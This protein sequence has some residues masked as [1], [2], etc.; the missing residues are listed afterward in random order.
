MQV[1]HT[2]NNCNPDCKVKHLIQEMFKWQREG[3][4]DRRIWASNIFPSSHTTV[5]CSPEEGPHHSQGAPAITDQELEAFNKE[6]LDPVIWVPKLCEQ[7]NIDNLKL[8]KE[9]GRGRVSKFLNGINN[10]MIQGALRCLL[11]ALRCLYVGS[12]HFEHLADLP[13]IINQRLAYLTRNRDENDPK[14]F[15]G[16][17]DEIECTIWQLHQYSSSS[18]EFLTCLATLSLFNF[19][20]DELCFVDILCEKDIEKLSEALSENFE[21]LNGLQRSKLK[22]AFVLKI[23][24]NNPFDENKVVRYVLE[25]LPNT[26]DTFDLKEIRKE[27]KRIL[28]KQD[29]KAFEE[30]Q[31]ILMDAF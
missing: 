6:Q 14:K 13:D 8:L 28:A 10:K 3:Y 7:F 16:L 29:A 26:V 2:W 31:K 1:L 17:I 15:E 23:A 22:R 27:V 11:R 20:L 19:S 25:K 21:E 12:F 18:Y 24:L 5:S 4:L 30:K 9:V